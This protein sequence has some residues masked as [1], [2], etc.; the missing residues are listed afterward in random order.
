[1]INPFCFIGCHNWEYRKEKH[2]VTNHPKGLPTIRVVVRECQWCG[3]REHHSLPRVGKKFTQWKTF[4]DIGKED[5]IDIKRVYDEFQ[6]E[7]TN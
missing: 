7:E 1:M 5:C 3:H 4:D 2:P 6:N